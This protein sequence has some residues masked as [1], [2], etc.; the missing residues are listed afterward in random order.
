M[1]IKGYLLFLVILVLSAAGTIIVA[2]SVTFSFCYSTPDDEMPI[3]A[4]ELENGN[5]IVTARKGIFPGLYQ[6]LFLTL[7]PDGDTIQS[8]ILSNPNGTC[9]IN[10]L[11]A[12]TAGQFFGI[13]SYQQSA[14][15]TSV[16]L[17]KM[18]ENLNLLWEKFYHTNCEYMGIVKG[19]RNSFNELVIFG[20]GYTGVIT[21]YDLFICKTTTT[22]DS[23]AFRFYPDP[24]I[25]FSWSMVENTNRGN[26]YFSNSGKFMINFNAN[27]N[28]ISIGYDLNVDTV[29][30]I[31]G[32]LFLYND[33]MMIGEH[34][35]NSG[36]K[37][38]SGPS[39]HLLNLLGIVLSDTSLTMLNADTL[40]SMDPDTLSYPGYIT[41]L[42]TNS[43]G[44]IYYGGTFNQD[45]SLFF[46]YLNSW[47]LLAKY[48]FNLNLQWQK[49][50][51]G[52]QN[53][54]LWGLMAT[55]DGGCLLLCST[56]D[57]Q[58]Q[59]DERDILVIKVDSNGLITATHDQP[60]IMTHDA[61][62]YP[63]PGSDHCVVILG[64]QHPAAHL[65]FYDLLG[66]KVME[67][68]LNQPQSRINTEALPSGTYVYQ[69]SADD[70][71]IGTGKWVKK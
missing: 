50:Y 27:A 8:D 9:Y 4:L 12:D 16:W 44:S 64:I 58:I 10:T 21:S 35:L 47:I 43:F 34:I 69:I 38:L 66:R 28:I 53:Y 65:C 18:D 36:I 41:N 17:I 42:D 49:F 61:I 23:L 2:Q 51:G 39:T 15:E 31:P 33:L 67:C 52:D 22:G 37:I 70:K 29:E 57:D 54:G 20:D 3:D 25:E 45:N 71:P 48:D 40:G 11:I 59:Y 26:Y 55:T 5:M 56:F 60:M 19:F 46:S 1:N 68:P 30:M 6:V 7:D 32:N 62:V 24:A 14:T 63:N 13:G